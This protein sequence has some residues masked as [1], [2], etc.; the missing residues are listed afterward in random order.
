M[1]V[2]EV[3]ILMEIHQELEKPCPNLNR[4]YFKWTGPTFELFSLAIVNL[5]KKG[6]INI[7]KGNIIYG[8]DKYHPEDVI[9]DNISVT[10]KGR[11]LIEKYKKWFS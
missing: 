5:K 7:P 9:L 8:G 3:E 2:L 1:T 11:M 6:L 10:V 4:V